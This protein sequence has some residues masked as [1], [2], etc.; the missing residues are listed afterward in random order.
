MSKEVD[1]QSKIIKWLRSQKCIVIK[2]QQNATTRASIPDIIFLKEGFW[3]AIEV[4]KTKTSP[5]RPGQREMVAKMDNM[6]WARVIYGGKDSNW[7]EVQKEL[8]EILR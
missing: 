3:G 6:S 2:Y 7:P 1:L 5:Y 8:T 4:K